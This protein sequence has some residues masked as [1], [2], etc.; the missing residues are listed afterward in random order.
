MIMNSGKIIKVVLVEENIM[1]MKIMMGVLVKEDK[2]VGKEI[3][4]EKE[5]VEEVVEIIIPI[6]IEIVVII[7][8]TT[9]TNITVHKTNNNFNFY[10][11]NQLHA[12]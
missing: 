7:Q 3:V 5:I 12:L 10:I 6:Y 8:V 9:I 11:Q 1:I 4:V 2:V